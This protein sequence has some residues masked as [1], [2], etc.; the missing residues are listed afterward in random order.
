MDIE[1]LYGSKDNQM[2]ACSVY[3]QANDDDTFTLTI[4]DNLNNTLL[5]TKLKGE[6]EKSENRCNECYSIDPTGNTDCARHRK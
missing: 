6:K 2:R 1:V 4:I 5:H 3:I